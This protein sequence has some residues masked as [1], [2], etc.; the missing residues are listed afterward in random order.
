MKMFC[1]FEPSLGFTSKCMLMGYV[2]PVPDP[3]DYILNNYS[4]SLKLLIKGGTLIDSSV[5]NTT[6]YVSGNTPTIKVNDQ[7]GNANSAFFYSGTYLGNDIGSSTGQTIMMWAKCLD[8]VTNYNGI[9]T[10]GGKDVK[11]GISACMS[12]NVSDVN[13]YCEYITYSDY[14]IVRTSRKV[15]LGSLSDW[16]LYTFV[17]NFSPAYMLIMVNGSNTYYSTSNFNKVG[18]INGSSIFGRSRNGV[19]GDVTNGSLLVG[20]I[21]YWNKGLTSGQVIDIWNNTK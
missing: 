16:C 18:V 2:P 17:E 15:P 21:S 3:T 7:Q 9:L 6:V 8:T 12:Y 14:G 5:N 13:D 1:G 10:A 11:S 4:D 19:V 20:F